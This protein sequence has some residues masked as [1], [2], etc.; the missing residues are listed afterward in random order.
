MAGRRTEQEARD[1]FRG[2]NERIKGLLTGS[3]I[4]IYATEG[5]VPVHFGTGTLFQLAD[6]R[7][8]V[9]AEHV[10]KEASEHGLPLFIAD[11]GEHAR[12]LR[13]RGTEIHAEDE[14][15]DVSVWPLQEELA[16]RLPN[17]RFLRLSNVLLEDRV[18]QGAFLFLGVPDALTSVDEERRTIGGS[19]FKYTTSLYTGSQPAISGYNP[20]CHM[21]FGLDKK[22]VTTL[23][24]DRYDLPSSLGGISGCSVW[25]TWAVGTPFDA[26][27]EDCVKVVGVQTGVYPSNK[28][29]KATR[30]LAVLGILRRRFPELD[31]VIRLH[32]SCQSGT[33]LL[34]SESS[35]SGFTRWPEQRP[36]RRKATRGLTGPP[37]R[38]SIRTSNRA[39]SS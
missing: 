31:R 23:D 4:P 34:R 2:V 24:G 35:N 29:I 19:Y 17:K 30:W 11:S 5:R 27:T 14:S 37:P 8:L 38:L 9:S 39:G 7:F 13:L 3:V 26:W 18:P 10:L 12:L 20:T 36:G 15:W 28:L 25:Q 16:E 33:G 6:Q 21:L 32:L 22:G 1:F